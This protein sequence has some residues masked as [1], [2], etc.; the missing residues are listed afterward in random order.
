MNKKYL[1]KMNKD[2]FFE[3][4]ESIC[5]DIFEGDVNL[6]TVSKKMQYYSFLHPYILK[7]YNE[8]ASRC[9]MKV[10]EVNKHDKNWNRRKTAIAAVFM[11]VDKYSYRVVG[12]EKIVELL[13]N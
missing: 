13:F 6:L 9:L 4:F 10:F 7:Y 11:E 5:R 2:M 8:I 12:Q 3:E 1:L